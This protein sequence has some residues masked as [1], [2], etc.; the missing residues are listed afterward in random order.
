M[1]QRTHETNR[2]ESIETL[3]RLLSAAHHM[4]PYDF[5]V[6]CTHLRNAMRA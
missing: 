5:D 4:T 2:L 6:Y 1:K 3:D